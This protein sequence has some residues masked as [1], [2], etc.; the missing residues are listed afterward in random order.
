MCQKR[1]EIFGDRHRGL[2]PEVK[3][4]ELYE[5]PKDIPIATRCAGSACALILRGET[6]FGCV[7][8]YRAGLNASSTDD[9][10][11]EVGGLRTVRCVDAFVAP[12]F[13]RG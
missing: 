8:R 1:P 5:L 9:K 6:L 11:V 13:L 12:V 2:T 3:A 4:I 10:A 7:K